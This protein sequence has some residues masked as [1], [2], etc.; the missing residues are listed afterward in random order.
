[1]LDPIVRTPAG[2]VKVP[3][4]MMRGLRSG[5]KV[6]GGIGLGITIYDISSD[7][8]NGNV[9]SAVTRATVAAI[10]YEVTFIPYAG[11]VLAIGIGIADYYWGDEFYDWINK[12]FSSLHIEWGH[13]IF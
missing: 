8:Y 13:I 2:N 3:S 6:M 10:A 9:P 11:W 1:V 7:I 12:E 5:G 4:K